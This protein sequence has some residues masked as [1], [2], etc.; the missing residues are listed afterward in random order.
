MSPRGAKSQA[1]AQ[2][3]ATPAKGLV[4]PLAAR[5]R[6]RTF[7]EFQGQTHLLGEGRALH[8]MIETARPTSMILWG[9]PGSGK[10]T[11]A[12]L[13]AEATGVRFVP[14]SAVTEGI[15]RVR[16]IIAEA[17]VR[18]EA[19]EPSTLLFCDEIHRFNKAQQDAFLP[20]VE[21]G[22]I[23]LVGATTENPSFEIVRPLLSRAPVYVLQPLTDDDIQAIVRQTLSDAERGLGA[24]KLKIGEEVL[25]QLARQADGDARRALG[26]L[27]AAAL[28]A[29]P[30]G[31]IDLQVL[32]EALQHRFAAYD[33]GGEAH[34]NLI[35]ALHKA[36][37]G[38]DADGA[39]YWLARMLDA[40]EDALYI[41]RRLVRMAS[42]DVGLADPQALEVTLAARDAFH[43]LGVPE[44]ELALAEA[45]VYLALAPKSNRVYRAWKAA[46]TAA[47]E[48]PAAEVPMHIRNAP[49]DL[50]KDLGYGKGYRYDP[51]TPEGVAPQAYL[52]EPLEGTRFYEPG[53]FGFEKT[54]AE[55]IAWFNR[56]RAE[57]RAREGDPGLG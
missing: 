26:V 46:R 53:R 13:F 6:P 33:K 56:R 3:A 21:A 52:P 44:G 7:A 41:A 15:A 47:R 23:V 28:I 32:K 5:M 24:L 18:L 50:M 16:E 12:R 20:H 38:S 43:F 45:T 10:T 51:D 30:G 31:T 42:E 29:G 11:L 17:E 39:L 25:T 48:Y 55:R 8:V 37:R 49:T 2:T 54:L 36:V 4:P 35:S 34:Y 22:T 1:T 57:A 40:G 19:G 27:E 9:P 14:F